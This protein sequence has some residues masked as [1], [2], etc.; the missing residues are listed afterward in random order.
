MEICASKLIKKSY[1]TLCNAGKHQDLWEIFANVKNIFGL[2][3]THSFTN[4]KSYQ[5]NLF[6]AR[7]NQQK[8]VK[9]FNDG[10]YSAVYISSMKLI[11]VFSCFIHVLIQTLTIS[12]H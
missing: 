8:E 9:F 1:R 12:F 7:T 5:Y 6:L 11:R 4:S 3:T 2:F 10:L